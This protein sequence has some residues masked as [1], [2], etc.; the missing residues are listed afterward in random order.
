MGEP[1]AGTDTGPTPVLANVLER[2]GFAAAL[3]LAEVAVLH[4]DHPRWAV[5]VPAAGAE[6]AAARPAGSRPPGP[7]VPMLWV[8]ADTVA[9][10]GGLMSRVDAGLLPS[11]HC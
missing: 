11:S 2:L 1:G 7:G 10:L 6:W 3:A 5:W 4:R 8:R 9:G